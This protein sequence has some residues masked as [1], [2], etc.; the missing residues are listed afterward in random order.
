MR[1]DA[2]VGAMNDAMDLEDGARL[3]QILAVYRERFPEDPSQLQE[4]YGVIADCLERPSA[5]ARAAA[6][7]YYDEERGSIL[8]LF[9]GRHCLAVE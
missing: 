5:D 4:G 2:I 3:R 6:Q 7:R 9:V 8:R 1:M